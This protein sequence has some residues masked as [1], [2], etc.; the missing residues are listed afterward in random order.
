MRD[1]R[2][3]SGAAA[4]PSDA[5]SPRRRVLA[6]AF[7]LTAPPAV[8]A[9]AAAAFSGGSELSA[10]GVGV[11]A[12][13]GAGLAA[14]LRERRGTVE[15]RARVEA[16]PVRRSGR[17]IAEFVPLVLFVLDARGLVLFANAAAVAE[18][19]DRLVGQRFSLI[20][21]APTL[22]EAI[23]VALADR[24]AEESASEASFVLHGDRERHMA[25]IVRAVPPAHDGAWGGE[26][27][28]ALEDRRAAALVMIQ[29][30]TRARRAEKLHRDFVANASHELKT[31]LTSISGLVETL[32]GHA[33]DDPEARERFLGIVAT[34]ADRMIHLVQDLLSLNRIELNEHLAP[35]DIVDLRGAVEAAARAADPGPGSGAA[36]ECSVELPKDLPAARGDARE[37]TMLFT[38]LISNALKY[39][40]DAR[41]P[42]VYAEPIVDGADRIGVTVEDYGPGIAKE[43]IPRLC[44]RFYRVEEGPTGAKAGTGLGLAIVKHVVSRHRGELAIWSRLGRGSRFTVWLPA[45]LERGSH[46]VTSKSRELADLD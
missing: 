30:V 5:V 11:G 14:L 22:T 17:E 36:L 41:P 37:L 40:G 3:L 45:A 35:R 18:F 7:R 16:A 24:G 29:D 31:P 21:R 20:L 2:G 25:A 9:I 44:E 46:N 27:G 4:R 33:R 6:R 42:R 10:V 8:A 28:L 1:E 34:Q 26:A 32:R 38:N 39:G 23:D 13:V 12:A 43:H 19:G 15:P